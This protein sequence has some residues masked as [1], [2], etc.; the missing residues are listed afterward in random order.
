VGRGKVRGKGLGTPQKLYAAYAHV[1]YVSLLY[2]CSAQLKPSFLLEGWL[3][4][5]ISATQSI[6]AVIY[7]RNNT[8]NVYKS[9]ARNDET[10]A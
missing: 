7:G 1:N 5:N 2:V 6:I 4:L 8:I 10:Y 9:F 3:Q